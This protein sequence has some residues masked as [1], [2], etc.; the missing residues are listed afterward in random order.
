M[1]KKEVLN[2]LMEQ[3]MIRVPTLNRGEYYELNNIPSDCVKL[4]NPEIYIHKGNNDGMNYSKGFLSEMIH[5]IPELKQSGE[6]S[7]RL[8]S[9]LESLLLALDRLIFPS[10][11]EQ[12]ASETLKEELDSIFSEF[13][14]IE[15][16]HAFLDTRKRSTHIKRTIVADTVSNSVR[17]ERDPAVDDEIES[18]TLFKGKMSSK[19]HIEQL[20]YVWMNSYNDNTKESER[21]L[22][23]L[24]VN[25]LMRWFF[26][27]ASWRAGVLSPFDELSIF[28]KLGT[29]YRA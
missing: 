27:S 11:R 17:I 6:I 2:A 4:I 29:V 24:H 25:H 7:E 10:E 13:L 12:Q 23:V 21:D 9:V 1:R 3:G 28:I 26:E 14:R 5:F 15:K 16:A 22:T 19:E 20:G 18:V 8:F